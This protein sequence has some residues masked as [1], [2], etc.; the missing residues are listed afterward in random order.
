M[1]RIT[2]LTIFIVSVFLV[3]VLIYILTRQN[4][5]EDFRIINY[6]LSASPAGG[7]DKTYKLLVADTP[8]KWTKGLMNY[9][10]L[11]GVDGM[12]FLFQ[13]RQLRTFWNNNTFLDLD[14]YWIDGDKVVAK[15][16]LPSIEKSKEIVIVNSPQ[17]ADKVIE[18]P[19]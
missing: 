6:K 4:Q 10:K 7:Q 11:E 19:L 9:R 3:G 13:D 15:S 2:I 14:L 1:K 5:Y 8:E 16:Y 12:I 17:P 18:L